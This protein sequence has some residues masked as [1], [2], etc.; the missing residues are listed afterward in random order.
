MHSRYWLLLALPL[1]LGA[2]GIAF[3]LRFDGL[4]GQD[5]FAYYNYASGPLRTALLTAAPWPYFF[6]PPGYP[7]ALTLATF[8]LGLT[9]LA[10]Q[11]L[12]LLAGSLVPVVTALWAHELFPENKNLPWVAGIIAALTPQL[13]QSSIVVMA[14]TLGLLC[15]VVGA[16]ATTRYARTLALARAERLTRAEPVE[17]PPLTQGIPWLLLASTA[18]AYAILTRWI[19]GLAALPSIVYILYLIIR[20]T[21]F[22]RP[23]APLQIFIRLFIT[24]S[25]A[26]IPG[27]LILSPLF[28]ATVQAAQT[29]T[30]LIPFAGN[31]QVHSWQ[32]ANFFQ[33]E[34]STPDG[35]LSYALPNF[36]YYLT[37]PAQRL[38]FT[39]IVAFFISLG[40]WPLMR[41]RQWA[42]LFL[43]GG[44]ASLVIAY[45]SGD[46]WQNVRFNLAHLPPLA[47]LAALGWG[48][49]GQWVKQWRG[50]RPFDRLMAQPAWLAY[51]WLALGLCAMLLSSVQ[52]VHSFSTRQLQNLALVQRVDPHLPTGSRL[53]TFGLTAT[54]Q[55]YGQHETLELYELDQTEIALLLADPR[56]LYILL[57]TRAIEAQWSAMPLGATYRWL[58][59]QLTPQAQFDAYTLFCAQGC[60]AP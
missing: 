43:L 14:D 34:F 46:P 42:N 35:Q 31:L 53:I 60:V 22:S 37:F 15:A 32:L 12:S 48:A 52:L 3:A 28:S 51:G 10:G 5:A 39:P 44:W 54:F 8:I 26:I 11:L 41:Q 57:D 30:A 4:Y 49:L 9:P 27:L 55:H 38:Y 45:H 19:Y 25:L 50:L 29:P 21:F 24:P 33:R 56:P 16:W 40:L 36:F 18:W 23:S 1:L 59:P 58:Q 7:F 13:W 17:A 6:W 2:G 20:N 47:I